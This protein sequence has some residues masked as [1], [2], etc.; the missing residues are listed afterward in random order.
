MLHPPSSKPWRTLIG[1]WKFSTCDR[2]SKMLSWR[3]GGKHCFLMRRPCANGIN[4]NHT[5]HSELMP[6]ICAQAFMHGCGRHSKLWGVS[7]DHFQ[8]CANT[9][10]H[11][12]IFL[13]IL[14]LKRPSNRSSYIC[15]LF[16]SSCPIHYGT[17][18][19]EKCQ[20]VYFCEFTHFVWPLSLGY[21]L[22]AS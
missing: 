14:I 13:P 11:Q 21:K 5:E 22:W 3:L 18:V 1:S 6:L 10:I 15:L 4:E 16:H 17:R 8:I 9:T 12:L 7:R 2:A 19:G 20:Y